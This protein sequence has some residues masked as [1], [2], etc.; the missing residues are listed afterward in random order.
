MGRAWRASCWK[1][2]SG[3]IQL[4]RP[5]RTPRRSW[6]KSDPIDAIR[7]ARE[8]LGR[9]KLAEPK[10]GS[11]RA[12]LAARLGARCSA[13]D[14]WTDVHATCTPIAASARIESTS[15]S[16]TIPIC[17]NRAALFRRAMDTRVLA[18]LL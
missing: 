3:V 12:A 4:D 7:A 2:V 9:T 1:P 6:A 15:R 8:A 10:I 17:S 18:T 13:V 11:E 14:S 16:A 5:H